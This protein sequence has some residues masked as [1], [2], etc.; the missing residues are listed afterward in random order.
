MIAMSKI[1]IIT[2]RNHVFHV[3][4][5]IQ[6][7]VLRG[8]LMKNDFNFCEKGIFSGCPSSTTFSSMEVFVGCT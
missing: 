7:I 2:M 1:V 6:F 4:L 8:R 5:F 3:Q